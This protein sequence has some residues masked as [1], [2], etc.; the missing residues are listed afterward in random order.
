MYCNGLETAA[1]THACFARHEVYV[2][3]K[4]PA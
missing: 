2:S 1:Q 4:L 3:R